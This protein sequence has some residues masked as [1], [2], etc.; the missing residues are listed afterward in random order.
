MPDPKP[1]KRPGPL[2]HTDPDG[3][4]WTPH[5][6]DH[7]LLD[8]KTLLGV[9]LHSADRNELERRLDDLERY[10]NMFLVV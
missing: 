4:K 5:A 8:V 6:V 1:R 3:N 10:L 7:L 2:L 9:K